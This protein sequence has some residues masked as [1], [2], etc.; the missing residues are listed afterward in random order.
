MP[1]FI[2]CFV[3]WDKLEKEIKNFN[4]SKL[5]YINKIAQILLKYNNDIYSEGIWKI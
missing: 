2:Y 5:N 1:F 3:I 4:K